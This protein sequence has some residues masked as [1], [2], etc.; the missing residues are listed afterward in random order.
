[1]ISGGNRRTKV[2]TELANHEIVTLAVYL[3]GGRT[4]VVDTEDIAVKANELAPGRFVWK[5]YPDQINLEIIRVYL[6]DA[7][8]ESK[9]AYLSGSGTDGWALTQHGLAFARK[10]AKVLGSADLSREALDP[11]EKR[12]RRGER[13]RLLSSEAFRKF[14]AGDIRNISVSEAA[15]FFRVDDY[16]APEMRQRRVTRIINAFGNDPTLGKAITAL[17]EIAGR[18]Q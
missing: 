10:H 12:W 16:V 14:A 6:S 13:A 17:A 2:P 3:I 18:S 7:K 5:K 1:M 11:R 4:R 9:G 15:A 8:K